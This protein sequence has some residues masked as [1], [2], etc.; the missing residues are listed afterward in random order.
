MANV[1]RDFILEH[2]EYHHWAANRVLEAVAAVSADRLDD[3]WGGSFKTGRALL[4]HVVGVE[5]LWCERWNGRSP[6]AV[7]EYPATWGGREFFGQWQKAREEQNEFL[8]RLTR[9]M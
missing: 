5:F 1:D 4:R 8:G 7:P 3:E 6:S 2:F 9:D